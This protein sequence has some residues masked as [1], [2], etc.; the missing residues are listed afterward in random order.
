MMMASIF[1]MGT[2]VASPRNILSK[3]ESHRIIMQGDGGLELW[4]GSIVRGQRTLVNRPTAH[5]IVDYEY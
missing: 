5:S 2:G 1:K 4:S 3:E